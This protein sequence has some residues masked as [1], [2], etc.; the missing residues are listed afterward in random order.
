MRIEFDLNDEAEAAE[1]LDM[2][3]KRHR[4]QTHTKDMPQF[5]RMRD[6]LLHVLGMYPD[7]ISSSKLF[8]LLEGKV[9]TANCQGFRV[10]A[11]SSL[12]GLTREGI[13]KRLGRRRYKLNPKADRP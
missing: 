13:V 6:G 1:V 12:S 3:L 5:R 8:N 10:A 9:D 4:P 2:I 11:T 7:G